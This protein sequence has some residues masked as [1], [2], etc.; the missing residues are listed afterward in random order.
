[1]GSTRACRRGL[2]RCPLDE[3]RR[4]GGARGLANPSGSRCRRRPAGA[5]LESHKLGAGRQDPEFGECLATSE[6]AWGELW[7]SLRARR[8]DGGA[9][10]ILRHPGADKV[11][12]PLWALGPFRAGGEA[13][14]AEVARRHDPRK[15]L[16]GHGGLRHGYL[17]AA[18]GILEFCHVSRRR[19]ARS[20]PGL[21]C[22]G[23]EAEESPPAGFARG[24]SAVPGSSFQLCQ[25]ARNQDS[26]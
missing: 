11:R 19:R 18:C 2:P 23:R 15:G 13:A 7:E 22:R 24:V 25:E 16:R 9:L 3:H 1:M 26:P 14:H 5:P 21:G 17:P 10:Q 8:L 20:A 4:C 12:L 6:V